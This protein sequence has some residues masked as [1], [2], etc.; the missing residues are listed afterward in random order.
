MIL[1]HGSR[2]TVDTPDPDFAL[3]EAEWPRGLPNRQRD[4]ALLLLHAGQ[5]LLARNRPAEAEAALR[6]A[7]DLSDP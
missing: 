6:E 5:R 7:E 2:I 4:R 1:G 3:A